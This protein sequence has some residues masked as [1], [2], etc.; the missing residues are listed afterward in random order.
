MYGTY[1]GTIGTDEEMILDDRTARNYGLGEDSTLSGLSIIKPSSPEE[2]DEFA[3][4]YGDTVKAA[5]SSEEEE[6]DFDWSPAGDND[7]EE[8]DYS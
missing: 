7:E 8:D 3:G 5:A 2:E 1:E 6:E 4:L